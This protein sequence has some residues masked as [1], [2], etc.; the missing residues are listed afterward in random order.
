MRANVAPKNGVLK[1]HMNYSLPDLFFKIHQAAIKVNNHFI[2]KN[3]S[4][5]SD[6]IFITSGKA[7]VTLLQ[8]V[9]VVEN[10]ELNFSFQVSLQGI[11]K[12]GKLGSC[13]FRSVNCQFFSIQVKVC[14]EAVELVVGPQKLLKLYPASSKIHLVAVVKLSLSF[15]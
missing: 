14:I 8:V 10:D 5:A 12:S 3:M 6:V 4:D 11:F 7:N 15:C 13:I 1:Q 9:E 2:S